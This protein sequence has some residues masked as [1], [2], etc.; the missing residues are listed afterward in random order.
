MNRGF[1]ITG[2][3]TGVG[4]TVVAAALAIVLRESGRDVGV[5][6]PVASGCVR[7][8]EGLVSEDAEFLAKAAEAP[9]TL[10]EI[11][12]IRFEAPLAP[13]VAA[14][15]AGVETDLE[16]MWEA[17]RRLRDAHEILLV[18]GIGG[19]LCP[20]TPAMSVADLAKEFRLPLLV[21]ARSTLGTINHT[22]LVIEA[23]RARGLAVAGVVI[24]RYNHES[25]DLAEMTSP[26][27]IWRVTGVRVLGLVPE[28]RA[29]DFRA[30]VVGPDVLAA[31]RQLPLN[32]LL[33]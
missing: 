6:K 29:T 15:R 12:P 26:D 18:E 4:K 17:W 30:G 7:R 21:V 8:R 24:N 19:I 33:A 14:A 5:F 13:T 32:R 10:E 25:P 2:T 11:S 1:F 31:V 27:E 3:D 23:A 20:V 9:E 28:D 22:A 16:P